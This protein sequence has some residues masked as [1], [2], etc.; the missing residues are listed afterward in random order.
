MGELIRALCLVAVLEGLF[1]FVAPGGWKR[2]A[3]Q[4]QALPDK[5]L[6]IVGGI[7]VAVAVIALWVLRAV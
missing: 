3:E 2:A 5:Q 6:R 4:L 7:V 1:L